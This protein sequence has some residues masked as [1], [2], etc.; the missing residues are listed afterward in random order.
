MS[1]ENNTKSF[2][3]LRGHIPL[4]YFLSQT[5]ILLEEAEVTAISNNNH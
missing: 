5:F 4:D 3:F 2:Y 1:L